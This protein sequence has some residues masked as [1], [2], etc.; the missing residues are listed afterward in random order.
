MPRLGHKKSRNGCRQCKARHVKCDENKP[1]SSCARHGVQC[2]LITCDP[3]APVSPPVGPATR[4][5]ASSSRATKPTSQTKE[6]PSTQVL[7][8]ASLPIEYVLNPSPVPAASSPDGVSNH[9]S[10]DPFPYL[11]KFANK[12]ESI[13]PN[14]WARDLE[15]MH[16]WSTNAYLTLSERDDIR[17]MWQIT[18]PRQAITH[19]FLMHEI[20]AYSALH[21]AFLYADQ[22]RSYYA[23]GTHHQNLAIRNM[24]AILPNMSADNAPALFAVSVLIA[25][26]ALGAGSLDITGS[27]SPI[28]DL[29]DLYALMQGVSHLLTSAQSE[30]F[31]GPFNGIFRE[32]P[33]DTPQQPILHHI[34]HH[35]DDVT[36]FLD[37]NAIGEDAH[38][39][40]VEAINSLKGAI[41]QSTDP[42]ADCRE[43]RIAFL[44]PIRISPNFLQMVRQK[45]PVALGIM[46]HYCIVLR[47]AEHTYWFVRGW[48]ERVINEIS[49]VIDPSWRQ[50]VR[51]PAEFIA[52]H[53]VQEQSK[54]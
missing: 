6:K 49:E 15:L 36:A 53:A 40:Y 5:A 19:Q 33:T 18:A 39:E 1:C 31:E 20:L 24:R 51:W 11:S 42:Q 17:Y 34:L 52:A 27:Q 4:S 45:Q 12:S 37:I 28:D 8:P 22:R 54:S 30:I 9:S 7:T 41:A 21:L 43:I 10:L 26:T 38:K 25:L 2:S 46:A 44:W 23:L 13:Q 16:H 3:G 14:Y 32:S 35:I 50:V 48:A 47:A 29:L